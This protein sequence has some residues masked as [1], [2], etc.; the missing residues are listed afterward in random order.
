MHAIYFKTMQHLR[1]PPFFRRIHTLVRT[2]QTTEIC[3]NATQSHTVSLV[4]VLRVRKGRGLRASMLSD[5]LTPWTPTGVE[6][7]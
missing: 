5:S 1:S 2:V 4:P 7:N 3:A 6:Y